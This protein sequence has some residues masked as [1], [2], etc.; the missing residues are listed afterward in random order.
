MERA[1]RQ[2]LR[3]PDRRALLFGAALAFL[4]PVAWAAP[5]SLLLIGPYVQGGFALGRT[6]PRATIVVDGVVEGVASSD[7]VFVVG[8][9]RDSPT[10]VT[11]AARTPTGEARHVQTIARGRFDVQRTLAPA[12]KPVET[13]PDPL[14]RARQAAETQRKA[15]GFASRVDSQDFAEGFILPVEGARVLTRFGTQRILGDRPAP[16]C[17]A[18]DF[19]A[20]LG[21]AVQAPAD[22]VVVTAESGAYFDGGLVMIDHGQGLVS[23]YQ[24]LSQVDVAVGDHV[25][26]GQLIGAVGQE[27][28]AGAP[29]LSWR[30]Q[31]HGRNLDPLLMVGAEAPDK[32]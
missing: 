2:G 14:A 32:L 15:A 19:G 17:Y 7:G 11:I 31:W 26:R 30:L 20:P 18:V 8:F 4:P 1:E 3:S 10:E 27:G 24:H 5:P 13:P 25:H 16:P 29:R 28:R 12:A 22:G 21:A 9:D 23:A 6:A